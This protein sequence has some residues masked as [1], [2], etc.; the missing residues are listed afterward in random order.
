MVEIL[1]ILCELVFG[2]IIYLC[3]VVSHKICPFSIIPSHYFLFLQR[4]VKIS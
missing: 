3:Y 1:H 4:T 2:L